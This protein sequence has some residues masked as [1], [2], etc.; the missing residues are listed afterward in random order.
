MPSLPLAAQ[1]YQDAPN[2]FPPEICINLYPEKAG[3]QQG[4]PYNLIGV[5]GLAAFAT[6]TSGNIRGWF[7]LPGVLESYL[8]VAVGTTIYKVLPDGTSS[9]LTGSIPSGTTRVKFAG[10]STAQLACCV[11]GLGFVLSTTAVVQI[12]DPD[13]PAVSDVAWL[14]N[15]FLWIR[16]D[17]GQLCWSAIADASDYDALSFATTERSPDN[18]VGLA[19]SDAYLLL[20]GQASTEFWSVTGDADLPFASATSSIL[21][22]GLMARDAVVQADNAVFFVGEDRILYAIS[23]ATQN[24]RIST[25]PIER[26]LGKL[27]DD[28]LGDLA[29]WYYADRGHTFVGLD[30][31]NE[32]T[33]VYDAATQRFH[34]RKSH[35]SEQWRCIGVQRYGA[36]L[37]AFPRTG[38][39]VLRLDDEVYD[40]VGD[41]LIAQFSSAAPI[42]SGRPSCDSIALQGS[43][44]VGLIT[45][46][47]SDPQIMMQYSDDRGNTW[48][49]EKWRGLGAI[50]QYTYRTIWRRLGSMRAPGRIFLFTVSDPVKRLFS[51]L[52]INE[53]MP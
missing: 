8:Y 45:G 28:D 30:I 1:A 21:Q 7:Y 39:S 14:N 4:A 10:G 9:A 24:Q 5:P 18:L 31:P 38:G 43:K 26:L 13:F 29:L 50:G 19:V 35:G 23:G 51:G 47:G 42:Q 37:I 52:T 15:Y 53:D 22:R 20:F 25:H 48:S 11:D 36:D 17:T 40:E 16:Q 6:T 3:E 33:F 32:G 27:S 34:E 46:Q 12:T 49:S 41:P 2:G 44:G